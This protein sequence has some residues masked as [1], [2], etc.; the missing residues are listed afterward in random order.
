MT[1]DIKFA[2]SW[3]LV[4]NHCEKDIEATLLLIEQVRCGVPPMPPV[5]VLDAVH[6]IIGFTEPDHP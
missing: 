3:I 2:A 4:Y 6:V 5:D 1:P